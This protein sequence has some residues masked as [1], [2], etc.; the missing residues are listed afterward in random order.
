MSDDIRYQACFPALHLLDLS[1]A[2]LF[3]VRLGHV[4]GVLVCNW[5]PKITSLLR[6]FNAQ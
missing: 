6:K 2:I 4:V 1:G 5:Q 3:G